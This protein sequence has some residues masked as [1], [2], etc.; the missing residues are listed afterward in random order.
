L[1][2]ILPGHTA[3]IGVEIVDSFNGG[4]NVACLNRSP[5]VHAIL[6][7]RY[8]NHWSQTTLNAE[9]FSSILVAFYHKVVH[10]EFVEI[11]A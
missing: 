8:I 3:Y 6:Y 7:R 5:N 4:I 2:H 11:P 1:D 9:L 10:Y